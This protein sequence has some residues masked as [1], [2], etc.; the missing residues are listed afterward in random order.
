MTLKKTA[1]FYSSYFSLNLI[2]SSV[3]T[4]L[5]LFGCY[6]TGRSNRPDS[7]TA[8]EITDRLVHRSAKIAMSQ[9]DTNLKNWCE[10]AIEEEVA[11]DDRL[12]RFYYQRS[13][14]NYQLFSL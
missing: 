11:I 2:I 6:L 7:D 9:N 8:I 13:T 12:S 3:I 1:Y 10:S 5:F 14:I 4:E